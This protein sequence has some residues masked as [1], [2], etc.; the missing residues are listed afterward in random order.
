NDAILDCCAL[1]EEP[2][3]CLGIVASA[4]GSFSGRVKIRGEGTQDWQDP[5]ASGGSFGLAVTSDWVTRPL[6]VWSDARCIIVIEKDG[7][8]N[9]LVEDGFYNRF[10]VD[11]CTTPPPPILGFYSR[12][13]SI[14]ITGRGFP[15]LAVRACVHRLA[16][17]LHLP[18][19]G[20]AD[21]N[22]FGECD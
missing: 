18:V 2:R 5:L 1:L 6:E 12:I 20:L 9:R 19:Y 14:L 3:H 8:F 16:K 22:P 13:P 4:R 10:V 21:C 17:A 15:A 11:R 7:I